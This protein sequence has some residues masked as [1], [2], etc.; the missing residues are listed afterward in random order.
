MCDDRPSFEELIQLE[1]RKESLIKSS[2]LGHISLL[3]SW[4]STVLSF[5]LFDIQFWFS[6]FLYL[7]FRYGIKTT[8]LPVNSIAIIVGFISFVLTF[9]LNNVLHRYF[10]MYENC[11]NCQGS[12]YN[13]AY[14]V[15][16]LLPEEEA[17]IITKYSITAYMLGFIGLSPVYDLDNLLLPI[18]N[19]YQLLNDAQIS[20]L[21]LIGLKE[22]GSS[23]REVIC[24]IMSIV[25]NQVQL[26]QLSELRSIE[27][28]NKI[29]I[30]RASINALFNIKALPIPFVYVNYVYFISFLYLPIFAVLVAENFPFDSKVEII[31]IL[32]VVLNCTFVIG[33][34]EISFRLNDP[35]G[36]DEEDF[37]VVSFI[38]RTA[39]GTLRLFGKLPLSTTGNRNHT[40]KDNKNS[41]KKLNRTRLQNVQDFFLDPLPPI[42]TT[43]TSNQRIQSQTNNNFIVDTNNPILKDYHDNINQSATDATVLYVYSIN[44]ENILPSVLRRNLSPHDSDSCS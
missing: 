3:L 22:S 7:L 10:T 14:M 19:K 24:W 38:L 40:G 20:K 30:L 42:N 5:V 2:Y 18:N 1:N 26:K 27:L 8:L 15:R 11:M 31:G 21:E 41:I 28:V 23:F 17:I 4:R 13:I 34:R 12:I 35:F 44:N 39:D 25:E 33:V 16:N 32:C 43:C 9:F 6:I 37:S 29:L 36:S